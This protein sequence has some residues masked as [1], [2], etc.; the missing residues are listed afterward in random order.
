MLRHFLNLQIR[1]HTCRLE[2]LADRAPRTCEALAALLPVDSHLVHAKF[3]GDEV[4]F[5]VPGAWLAENTVTQVA[6]GDVGYYPDRQTV[7]IF[8]GTIVP[9]GSVGLFARMVDGLEQ[10]RAIGPDLW[11]RGAVPVRLI[12]EAVR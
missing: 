4:Y 11:R 1:E 7:C 12:A 5:M 8:Y 3:A 2:L 6:P 9:F 10:L